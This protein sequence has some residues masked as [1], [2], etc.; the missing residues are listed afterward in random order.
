MQQFLDILDARAK[1]H[2]YGKPDFEL[3][4]N[5]VRLTISV[6]TRDDF[7]SAPAA[8]AEAQGLAADLLAVPGWVAV[9]DATIGATISVV[10]PRPRATTTRWHGLVKLNLVTDRALAE[11]ADEIVPFRRI[12]GFSE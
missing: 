3:E 11:S 2:D 10:P 9:S 5:G 6:Q 8:I 1:L 4:H 7:D 12:D